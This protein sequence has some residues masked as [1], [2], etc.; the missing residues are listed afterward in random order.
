MLLEIVS[1]ASI[2][3]ALLVDVSREKARRVVGPDERAGALPG[4]TG[5]D[6]PIWTVW[7]EVTHLYEPLVPSLEPWDFT[8]AL[9][10]MLSYARFE[11]RGPYDPY[12]PLPPGRYRVSVPGS[13]GGAVALPQA[14]DVTAAGG[15]YFLADTR[16]GSGQAFACPGLP[17]WVWLVQPA[18]AAAPGLLDLVPASAQ[19]PAVWAFRGR[20]GPPCRPEFMPSFR[21]PSG[22]GDPGSRL[23]ASPGAEAPGES[24]GRHAQPG[25]V[26][27]V[28]DLAEARALLERPGILLLVLHRHGCGLCVDVAPAIDAAAMRLGPD[29]KVLVLEAGLLAQATGPV[30]YRLW[31]TRFPTVRILKGGSLR[32]EVDDATIDRWIAL[33]GPQAGADIVERIRASTAG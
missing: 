21:S 9:R 16:T 17:K 6:G 2:M 13:D 14:L 1:I 24:Y 3:T 31:T 4:P 8:P 22:L 26:R 18:G 10:A 20:P 33:P 7:P 19:G 28:G 15:R 12:V 25:E 27:V 11:G 23:P 5:Y 30:D 32:D 29:A